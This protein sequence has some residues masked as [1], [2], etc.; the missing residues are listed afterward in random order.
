MPYPDIDDNP[1]AALYIA[2]TLAVNT[3]FCAVCLF[4]FFTWRF[5]K[6]SLHSAQ[7]NMAQL[8]AAVD[9]TDSHMQALRLLCFA[10]RKCQ[11]PDARARWRDCKLCSWSV[12]E[13][14]FR[15]QILSQVKLRL[16]R[17]AT[18]PIPSWVGLHM[19]RDTLLS[20]GATPKDLN[21]MFP[22]A[23]S[24][25][26]GFE[27]QDFDAENLRPKGKACAIRLAVNSA[28]PGT[29]VL[30]APFLPDAPLRV[31]SMRLLRMVDFV[32][33]YL[34]ST[35][36]QSLAPLRARAV[37]AAEQYGLS[38]EV[39]AFAGVQREHLVQK[40]YVTVT[41]DV[42]VYVLR[43]NNDRQYVLMLVEANDHHVEARLGTDLPE[44]DETL[45]DVAD[46]R[47]SIYSPDLPNILLSEWYWETVG[48]CTNSMVE[49]L[50]EECCEHTAQ[51][52]LSLVP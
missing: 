45:R 51:L 42:E 34:G 22:N 19:L 43:L 27:Y 15:H 36:R 24:V 40:E 30:V 26:I 16:L 11:M 44:W 37:A 9:G 49:E 46:L 7:L 52:S 21:W 12:P 8:W 18:I 35:L 20:A 6:V 5:Y 14:V 2:L 39:H 4:I 41:N 47:W 3:F 13:E 17:E 28:S 23:R 29:Q 31:S 48:A 38:M 1:G 50:C 25:S 33:A 10:W 32:H